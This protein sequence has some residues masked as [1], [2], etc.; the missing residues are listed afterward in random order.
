MGRKIAVRV[1]ETVGIGLIGDGVIGLLQPEQ[2]I[3]RWES[4]PSWWQRALKPF[5]G[6]ARNTRTF[7]AAEVVAGIAL[8]WLLPPG[9]KK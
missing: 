8:V 3:A 1:G 4:G 2:H 6:D 5:V 7:A 9:R